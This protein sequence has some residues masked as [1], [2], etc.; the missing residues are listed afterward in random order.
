MK[1][2]ALRDSRSE[3]AASRRSTCR[4]C[5]FAFMTIYRIRIG[6]QPT[7]WAIECN[8]QIIRT[9]PSA[10]VLG[11]YLDSIL[12]GETDYDADDTAKAIE[13]QPS[14]SYEER[15]AVFSPTGRP[16]PSRDLFPKVGRPSRISASFAATSRS[17]ASL[18]TDR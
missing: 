16:E 2:Y 10:A 4:F 15:M 5:T 14:L 9:H 18:S 17:I 8:G 11:A 7:G 6:S 13:R 3:D 1:R 12:A